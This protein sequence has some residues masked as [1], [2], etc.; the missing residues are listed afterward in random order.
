VADVAASSARTT[1]PTTQTLIGIGVISA[2]CEMA[3][4]QVAR[5]I[6]PHPTQTELFG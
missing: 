4:T 2:T 5:A 1:S 3:L 6:F